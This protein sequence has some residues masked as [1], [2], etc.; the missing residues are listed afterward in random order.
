MD[1]ILKGIFEQIIY[2][3]LYIFILFFWKIFLKHILW[4]LP[5]LVQD[6]IKVSF[7]GLGY[8]AMS[9]WLF[10][11][12]SIANIGLRWLNLFVVTVL[13]GYGMLWLYSKIEKLRD[14]RKDKVNIFASGSLFALIFCGL[15]LIVLS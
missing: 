12:L 8:G 3:I 9:C 14:S 6:L 13:A 15:R 1:E 5:P 11:K 7:L 2:L 10:P 4:K